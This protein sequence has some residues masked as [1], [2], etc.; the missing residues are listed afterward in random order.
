MAHLFQPP[1]APAALRPGVRVVDWE[2]FR[3]SVAERYAAGPQS[4]YAE[5]LR[6]DLAA[7]FERFAAPPAVVR[8]EVPA[9]ARA[10]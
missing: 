2:R 8:S 4:R 5:G 7:L 1:A 9:F 3:A 6:Q 10:A